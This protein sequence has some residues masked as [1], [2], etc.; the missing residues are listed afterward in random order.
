MSPV[1]IILSN[2]REWG[3]AFEA[4]PLNELAELRR[5]LVRVLISR[6]VRDPRPEAD[7]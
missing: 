3:V 4:M 1:P 7:R 5:V 2:L 6:R